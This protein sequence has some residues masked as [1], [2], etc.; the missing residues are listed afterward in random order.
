MFTKGNGLS[1]Q[2]H[3]A[4]IQQNNYDNPVLTSYAEENEIF[5]YL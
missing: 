3:V 5:F 4:G 1:H 2:P